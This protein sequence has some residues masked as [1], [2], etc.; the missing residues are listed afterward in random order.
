MLVVTLSMRVLLSS[1]VSGVMIVEG[2]VGSSSSSRRLGVD[3][4]SEIGDVLRY[5]CRY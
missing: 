5:A 3:E 1:L 4:C 2:W